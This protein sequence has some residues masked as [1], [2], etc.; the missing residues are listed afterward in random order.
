MR[1]PGPDVRTLKVDLDPLA[2]AVVYI[3]HAFSRE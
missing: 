3:H 2:D 1:P